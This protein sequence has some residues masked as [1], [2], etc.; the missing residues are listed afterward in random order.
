M[1]SPKEIWD[2][3]LRREMPTEAL[4]L[5][6]DVHRQRME[7]LRHGLSES[8]YSVSTSKHGLGCRACS[9]KTPI[10]FHDVAERYGEGEPPG[11]VFVDREPRQR[12]VPES[13]WGAATGQDLILTR[14][15]RLRGLDD[16]VNRGPDV[17]SYERYIYLHGSDNENA[18]GVKPSS[19]GCIH[20]G[21]RDLVEL[22]DRAKGC[23][24]WC[25]IG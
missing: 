14:I 12:V 2:V 3:A 4:L 5:V 18:L 8:A 10:G 15:L 1:R 16:G 24:T 23:P 7:V 17:D 19:H 20:V 9:L 21:N 6:V 25:W 13:A 11:R 22:F